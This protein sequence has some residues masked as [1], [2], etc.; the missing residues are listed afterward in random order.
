MHL[1]AARTVKSKHMSCWSPNKPARS[2]RRYPVVPALLWIALWFSLN[3]GP[4]VL[5]RGPHSAIGWIHGIRA[6]FPHVVLLLAC[7][8]MMTQSQSG[9][10]TKLPTSIMLWGLY[11]IVGLV[12]C[13]LS[14]SPIEAGYWGLAYLGAIVGVTAFLRSGDAIHRAVQLNYLSWV[15]TTVFLLTMV[16]LARD[17]LFANPES[18]YGVIGRQGQVLAMPMSRASGLGRF[19][20][21]PALVGLGYLLCRR[22]TLRITGG[23]ALTISLG[24]FIYYLQ[25]RG[26][27]IGF[28]GAALVVMVLAG[29][30]GKALLC[31]LLLLCFCAW[32]MQSIPEAIWV[33]LARG[34]SVQQ[35]QTLTGRTSFWRQGIEALSASPIIGQGAQAARAL[36]IGEIHNTCLAALLTS[37]LVGGIAFI[38]GLLSAL[39]DVY[40][41]TTQGMGARRDQ[42]MM[43]AQTGGIIAFFALRGIVEESGSLFNVDLLVILPAMAYVGSLARARLETTRSLRR[44]RMKSK[45]DRRATKYS[46]VP[47]EPVSWHGRR[48]RV[49]RRSSGRI[50]NM[51]PGRWS[52]AAKSTRGKGEQWG[53]SKQ[54]T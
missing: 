54:E 27:I 47:D 38:I 26:A 50:P 39:A 25:S 6:F 52:L 24:A 42:R 33:H 17:A 4:W 28:A 19:A 16:L 18:G 43:L 31:G 7:L 46:V 2:A 21:V 8:Y 10:K 3:T 23:T 11:A 35:I 9:A 32:A 12:A 53:Q 48:G 14:P 37:G 41:A 29:I 5:E 40:R 34:Q 36:G 30:R 49:R 20:A 45:R 51:S 22:G 15:L 13:V 44:M 1:S